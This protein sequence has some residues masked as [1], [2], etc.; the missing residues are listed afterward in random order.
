MKKKIT[1]KLPL[2]FLLFL[3]VAIISM[4][5]LSHGSVWAESKTPEVMLGGLPIS[6]ISIPKDFFF[7]VVHP[8]QRLDFFKTI[9][10][11]KINFVSSGTMF[12]GQNQVTCIPWPTEAQNAFTYAAGIWETYIQ[13][14]VPITIDACW[15]TGFDNPNV[16]GRGGAVNYYR[17][18]QGAPIGDTWYPVALVNALHG[19][20]FDPQNSDI[21]NAF[22][23]TFNWYFG[24]DGNPG[25]GETDFVSVAMHEIAHGLGFLGS[26]DVSKGK[27]SWGYG[28]SSPGIYDRFTENGDGQSLIDTSLFPNPSASLSDQ[29]TSN[30]IYFNGTNANAANDG[31]RPKLYAPSTWSPGSSY[32]H[33]DFSTYYGTVNALMVYAIGT[34]TAIHIPGPIT[35]GIFRDIGW[36]TSPCSP[37]GM[38][39]NPSPLDGATGVSNSV[40][41][42]WPACAN[43]DYYDVYFGT[44]SDPPYIGNTSST[45]YSLYGLNYSTPYY[46]KI[47]AKNNCGNSAIGSVW[48]FT[49]ESTTC[50]IPGTPLNP[51]P[52]NR[53]KW[54]STGP[55]LRWSACPNTDSYDVYFGTSP[56]NISLVG[57]TLNTSYPL[58]DLK[59]DTTYY[60][61]ILATNQC[62][63]SITG[64]IWTF[65]TT[66]LNC[67]IFSFTDI[68]NMITPP[69]GIIGPITIQDINHT[70]S[71]CCYTIRPLVIKPD[72]S[73][74]PVLTQVDTCA[75]PGTRTNYLTLNIPSSAPEGDYTFGVLLTDLSVEIIGLETFN[76]TIKK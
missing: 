65:T 23:S 21:K 1:Y 69:G 16:L 32:S 68:Q 18:F 71:D 70:I 17:N 3:S 11:S 55:T 41:L 52:L 60:W 35:L 48:S 24:T 19:Y 26:M 5:F 57:N 51:S 12:N 64:G 9:T 66:S 37:P 36:M 6:L 49:T 53:T 40:T 58:S 76:F 73:I 30:N 43:T 8:P 44:S 22:N 27:G 15:G 67:I 31:N 34:A 47:V 7:R 13:S 28:T 29:L 46:W 25:S 74:I 56:D 75:P 59:N 72:G 54:I 4:M 50:P 2:V 33:L 38:P 20:D 42:S 63:A 62:G 45:S 14:S 61:M 10:T 39:S